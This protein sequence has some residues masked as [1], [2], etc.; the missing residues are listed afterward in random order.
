M[1]GLGDLFTEFLFEYPFLWPLYALGLW[2]FIIRPMFGAQAAAR[3]AETTIPEYK[4][5]GNG[6]TVN[7]AETDEQQTFCRADYSKL[8]IRTKQ[9]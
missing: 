8:L 7:P 6:E 2:H 5:G 9:A 3:L 1:N 4:S